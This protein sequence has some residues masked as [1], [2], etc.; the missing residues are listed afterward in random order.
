[1]MRLSGTGRKLVFGI[2]A[3]FVNC[4][5]S[6]VHLRWWNS[7]RDDITRKLYPMGNLWVVIYF[8][9]GTTFTKIFELLI[10]EFYRNK[11]WAN[12]PR[13]DQMGVLTS[14]TYLSC[15]V[16]LRIVSELSL[17]RQFVENYFSRLIDFID[18]RFTALAS[19]TCHLDGLVFHK[20]MRD[21]CSLP[22]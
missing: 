10:Q 4:P 18:K 17:V 21:T 11:I 6:R 13:F 2:I 12:L 15:R 20:N 1:M 22:T 5:G 7:W 3:S 16:I 9:Y 14:T 8:K 19:I